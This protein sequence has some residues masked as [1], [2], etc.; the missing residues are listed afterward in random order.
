MKEETKKEQVKKVEGITTVVPLRDHRLVQNEH[1]ISLK[2]DEMIDVP[3]H[4]IPA[5][6]AEKVI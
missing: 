5:L 6:K 1:D 3:S 2:K 4:F